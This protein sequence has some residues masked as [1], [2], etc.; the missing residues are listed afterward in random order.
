MLKKLGYAGA[1][2]T[3]PC[4]AGFVLLLL[5]GTAAGAWLTAH[6]GLAIGVFAAAFAFFLWLAMRPERATANGVDHAVCETCAPD[7]AGDAAAR[8][9]HATAHASRSGE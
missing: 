8:A 4:H 5:G 3:C 1:L 7:A 6:M 9:G 2:L